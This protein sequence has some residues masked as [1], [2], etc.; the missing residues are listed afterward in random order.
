MVFK[1]SCFYLG[2]HPRIGAMDVCPFIP[3]QNVTMEDCVECAKEFGEKLALDLDVPGLYYIL[4]SI[5]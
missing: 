2:E 3:V 4:I 5:Q 1:N